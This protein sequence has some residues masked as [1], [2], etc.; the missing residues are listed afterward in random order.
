MPGHETL[1][2]ITET[3]PGVDAGRSGQRVVIEP[4][5]P[6]LSCAACR[7]GRTSACPDRIILGFTARGTLAEKIAVP[8]EFAWPVPRHIGDADAVC[9]EPLSVA[10]TAIRRAGLDQDGPGQDAGEQGRCLVIG[11]GSQGSL[12]CLA[13]VWRGVTPHVLEPH[14]G[15]RALAE[16]LGARP[17]DPGPADPA[18]GGFGI[19]FETSGAPAALTEAVSRAAPGGTILLIGLNSQPAP[20]PT[21]L[22]VQKQLTIRGS[23]IYDHP[24]DFAGTLASVGPR[25]SPGQV[26]RARHP[27]AEAAAAFSAARDVPGKTWIRLED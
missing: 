27:L 13:L 17:A 8:A 7:A 10:L 9:V 4:N 16:E 22:V 2:E 20:L 25:L 26:L 15:R 14:A 24:R 6:C 3:G 11:A 21:Q 19:V 23:L 5:I 18:D 1:G 12:L